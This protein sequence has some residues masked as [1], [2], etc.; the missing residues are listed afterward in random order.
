[1]QD[2]AYAFLMVVITF[3]TALCCYAL[4]YAAL[5]VV[6]VPIGAKLASL[7]LKKK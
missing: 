7:F 5:A 1:M 6:M 4:G 2:N 3:A